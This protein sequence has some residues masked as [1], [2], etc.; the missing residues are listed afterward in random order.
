VSKRRIKKAE[1]DIA[2]VFGFEFLILENIASFFEK[3]KGF[4]D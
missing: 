3:V 2:S 4:N 1:A